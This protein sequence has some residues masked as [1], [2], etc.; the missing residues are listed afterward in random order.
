MTIHAQATR[1]LLLVSYLLIGGPVSSDTDTAKSLATYQLLQ[2]QG[3]EHFSEVRTEDNEYNWKLL[4]YRNKGEQFLSVFDQEKNKLVFEYSHQGPLD[5][6]IHHQ[7]IELDGYPPLIA[8]VWRRGVHGEQ[9][10]LLDPLNR[11]ILY[12]LTSAWPL[13]VQECRQSIAITLSG[14]TDKEGNPI[15][16]T[17]YWHSP[18]LI[19][20]SKGDGSGCKTETIPET[21]PPIDDSHLLPSLNQFM[22]TFDIAVKNKDFS[23]IKIF[24][25][26]DIL[27][28]FGGEGGMDEFL[29]NWKNNQSALFNML[30]EIRQGGGKLTGYQ[31]EAEIYCM[32]RMFTDFPASLNAFNHGVLVGEGIPIYAEPDKS[33]RVLTKLSHAIVEVD[34]WGTEE[35]SWQLITLK[36]GI[37]AYVKSKQVRSPIDYR[38]CFAQNN[39]GEWEMTQLVAGD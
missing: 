3:V 12:K 28:S 29:L 39:E 17:H 13:S 36:Q 22:K 16:E 1:W 20:I 37:Q 15:Q 24:V 27:N 23:A 35:N 18:D 38:A 14:V 33:S 26:S 31:G 32:P 11:K 21:I 6:Y 30:A 9:F 8:S 19:E 25:A 10:I 5:G 2:Q 34:D 4:I 7:L